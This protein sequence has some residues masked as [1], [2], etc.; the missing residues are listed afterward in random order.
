MDER[1]DIAPVA[2]QAASAPSRAAGLDE[3]AALARA[4]SVEMTW[5]DV[6]QLADCRSTLAPG[7]TVF[8]SHLPGQTWRQTLDTCVVIRS[9]GFEPVPHVPVRRLA[10]L[11]EFER[12]VAD[13]VARAHVARVLLIAGDSPR[14]IGPFSSTLEAL[15]TGVLAAHG[16]RRIFVAGH[17][18]GH[19][20]LTDDELRR[21]E[22]DKVEFAAAHGLELVFLTQFFFDAAPFLAW[23]ELMRAQGIRA[24]LVAG[25]AG[26]ARLTTLFKYAMRCGVGASVRALGSRPD[27]FAKLASERDPEPVIRAIALAGRDGALGEIGIHLFSF[28]GLAHTCAWLRSFAT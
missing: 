4:A 22:R 13:L 6:D 24:R 3:V 19:P 1:A 25:L 5:R 12:L 10:S 15:S 17:P 26:P 8:A 18:E 27:R 14:A 2:A 21:A 7:T 28:G 9:H 11:T 16:I 20:Q 23:I